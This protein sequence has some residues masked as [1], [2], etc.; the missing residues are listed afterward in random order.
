MR[1]LLI[2]LTVA[3]TAYSCK[4]KCVGQLPS[5]RGIN[6]F[7][8]E[9][10]F[11][12]KNSSTTSFTK[13]ESL[14][15]GAIS[16]NISIPSGKTVFLFHSNKKNYVKTIDLLECHEYDIILTKDSIVTFK[17]LDYNR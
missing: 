10:V 12:Y 1:L 15:P 5:I 9:A 17:P 6:E 3:F 14:L 11:Y 13:V 16:Q 7:K 2:I 4:K 8:S